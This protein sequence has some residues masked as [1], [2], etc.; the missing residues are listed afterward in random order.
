[1]R[2]VLYTPT[3]RVKWPRQS[4]SRMWHG[5]FK[6]MLK[7]RAMPHTDDM[8]QMLDDLGIQRTSMEDLRELFRKHY[9]AL[10]SGW[11]EERYIK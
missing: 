7:Q 5:P 4:D 9:P 1:M 3:G 8:R 2:E 6:R 10:V 11:D